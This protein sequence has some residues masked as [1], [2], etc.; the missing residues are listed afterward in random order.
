MPCRCISATSEPMEASRSRPVTARACPP[1]PGQVLI[2]GVSRRTVSS[3]PSNAC[4]SITQLS[5]DG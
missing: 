5:L 2:S 4:A 1:S 3:S